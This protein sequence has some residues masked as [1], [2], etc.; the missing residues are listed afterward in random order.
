MRA[1]TVLA[2]LLTLSCN[3]RFRFDESADAAAMRPPPCSGDGECGL[4]S[5]HC[6]AASGACVECT[7]DE[8]CAIGPLPRCDLARL[9]CVECLQS[10]ECPAG[11]VCEPST[12]HCR[13]T[14]TTVA[15]CAPGSLECEFEEGHNVCEQCET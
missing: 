3:A 12:L 13:A 2:V 6:E 11:G 9:R 5:L 7:T 14:C 15:D 10:S 1:A 8:H 4:P